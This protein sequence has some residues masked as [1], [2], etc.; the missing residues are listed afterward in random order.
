MKKAITILEERK[1]VAQLLAQELKHLPL[2][3]VLLIVTGYYSMA[4]LT[5]RVVPGIV[6]EAV[7]RGWHGSGK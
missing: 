5:G 6:G 3:Q 7:V 2:E 4:D 1:A